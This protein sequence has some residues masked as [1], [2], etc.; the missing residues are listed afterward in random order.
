MLVPGN[1]AGLFYSLD[2]ECLML[3]DPTRRAMEEQ[4][5]P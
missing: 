4:N 3:F 5:L 1:Y 2:G